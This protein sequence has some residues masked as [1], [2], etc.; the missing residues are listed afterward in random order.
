MDSL[1]SHTQTIETGLNG[2]TTKK[3]IFLN[4]PYLISHTFSH[5]R[6]GADNLK[7]HRLSLFNAA[8]TSKYFLD[9]ALDALWE[10]LD[11]LV[12]LLRVLP[13]LRLENNAYVLSG[14]VSRADW[15][16]LEY[17]ARKVKVFQTMPSDTIGRE[18]VPSTYIRIAQLQ[19]SALLPSLR[20]LC[21]SL[22]A[23]STST[24]HI[25]LFLSPSLESLEL[26]NTTD[27]ENTLV[28]SFLDTVS[29]PVL[30]RIVLHT[31]RLSSSTL[32][33][34]AK[35]KQLRTLEL[36]PLDTVYDSASWEVI[37]TLPSLANLTLKVISSQAER[38]SHLGDVWKGSNSEGGGPK[39][40]NALETL[41]VTTFFPLIR[42]LLESIESPCLKSIEVHPSIEWESIQG[43]RNLECLERDL[44]DI[45][46]MV[47]SKW[48][49]SLENLVIG[50]HNVGNSRYS[51][52]PQHSHTFSESITELLMDLHEIQT[53]HIQGW[54][55]ID[56]SDEVIVRR[57]VIS[58]PKLTTLILPVN[59]EESISLS[60][61]KT[62]ARKCPKLRHLQ[63]RL[64]VTSAIPSVTVRHRLGV[65]K[66][67][68]HHGSYTTEK[69]QCQIAVAR[70]L[71]SIFPY[72]ESIETLPGSKD[73]TRNFSEIHKLVKLCWDVRQ[74]AKRQK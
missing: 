4:N 25:F 24:S 29:S 66:V 6:V 68:Y 22:K 45:I 40:F 55:I 28:Q 70:Y 52:Q 50:Q 62:I 34:I 10:N 65:L 69:L 36:V 57:L 72:L 14:D 32:K 74:E 54:R 23:R 47:C 16:R 71:D 1:N 59:H 33:T 19:S 31:R 15:N 11:S 18:V 21:Y 20:H 17:Y 7:E 41:L 64:D 38:Q 30:K 8:L 9:A 49:Q 53:I 42:H 63:I 61:L 5:L 12:P 67:A 35:F 27:S 2:L 43:S 60:T 37:G 58:W 56:V 26:T 13:A 51:S 46:T 44:F 39:H 3:F 48:P 73:E